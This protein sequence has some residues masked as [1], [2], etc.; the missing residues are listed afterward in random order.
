M[1]LDDICID[2][3]VNGDQTAFISIY[4]QYVV[5]VYR[6]VYYRIYDKTDAEDITQEVFIKAW[7][8]I[9][10]YKSTGA[11]F[12]GWL[13]AIARNAVADY[14]RTK[15]KEISL[16][17]MESSGEITLT[18]SENLESQVENTL[19]QSRIRNA[20]MRLKGNKQTVMLMRFIEGLSYQEIAQA[21]HK[22]E[23][24]VRVILY[25]ALRDLRY[26]LQ[27]RENSR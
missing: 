24:A 22:S 5:Q 3:A 2:R 8:G 20:I 13:L 25:R 15:K 19:E 27:G 12:W 9:K 7:K 6:H 23:G 16:D 4:N 10:K 21:L 1:T 11:P 18:D 26:S 17:K 14:Y